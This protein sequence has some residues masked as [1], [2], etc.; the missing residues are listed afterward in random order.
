MG[1]K[2]YYAQCQAKHAIAGQKRTRKQYAKTQSMLD[3][4]AYVLRNGLI[5]YRTTIFAWCLSL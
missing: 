2:P 1:T 3:V 5:L 4:C